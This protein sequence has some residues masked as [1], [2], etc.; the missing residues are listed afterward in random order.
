MHQSPLKIRQFRYSS[1]NLAYVIYGGG[2]AVTVD[3]GAVGA[4]TAN[5]KI[6]LARS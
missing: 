4:I 6:Y 2:Q 3:G 5:P 1:D